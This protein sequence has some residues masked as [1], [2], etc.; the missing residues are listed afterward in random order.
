MAAKTR[1]ERDAGL[2]SALDALTGQRIRLTRPRRTL[3]GLIFAQ[4]GPFSA[5]DLAEK[6]SHAPKAEACDTVTVYRT[7]AVL[8]EA[9]II[10]RCDFSDG[11]ALYEVR[12]GAAAGHRH[13]HVVCTSCHKV[14]SLD[15][16]LV[17]GQE[18]ALR[19]LGYTELAHRLEFSGVCP[20]CSA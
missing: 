10:E 11:V 17:Q 9:K 19:R 4:R 6:T 13:H 18:L 20:R 12:H 2:R 7:L 5:G 8:E 1:A 3:L 15:F 14:E 16:C